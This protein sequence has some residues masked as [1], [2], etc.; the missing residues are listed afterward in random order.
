[1]RIYFT[2]LLSALFLFC[3]HNTLRAQELEFGVK[4]GTSFYSGDLSPKEFGLYTDDMNFAGG[5]YLRY[6][7]RPR[8]GIRVNGNFG[9]ISAEREAFAPNEL[10]DLVAI[11]RNF[12]SAITEF[13]AVLEYDLFYIGDK[14]SNFLA[15]YLFGGVGV[16]SFNPESTLDGSEYV[17]L[18]PL[19]TQAQ[20]SGPQYDATPYEL[21]TVVG[22]LGGGVRVRFADRIV[23]GLE[24][25]GRKPGTDY[26]DDISD[27]PVNYLDVLSQQPNGG[28]AARFSNPAVENVAEV[29]DL[30]YKR[31]GDAE[32]YYFVGSLTVGITIG[33]SG[34]NKSGCYKF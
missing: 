30:L 23:V 21:T 11:N 24:L 31:G 10:G 17:E 4:A 32:D 29:T 19:R 7:P 34:S 26:L 15:G 22:V 12:R 20:G 25:G 3:G 2:L 6:R 5:L 18:Q 13:N 28:L 14:E 27:T 33:A 16:L 8:Y 9:R 1:M